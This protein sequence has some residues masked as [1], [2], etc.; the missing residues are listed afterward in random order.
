MEQRRFAKEL[1]TNQTVPEQ[2][3]WHEFRARRLEGWKFRRQVPIEGYVA[4]FVCFEAR[5]IVEM[6]GPLHRTPERQQ[7]DAARDAVL[8]RGFRTLRFDDETALGRIVDDIRDSLK[9]AP[10]PGL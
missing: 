10:S 3:L 1:R 4:D 6:D 2:R 8:G 5:L 7:R 9:P